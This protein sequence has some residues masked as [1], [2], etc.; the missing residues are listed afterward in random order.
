MWYSVWITNKLESL[1]LF[2]HAKRQTSLDLNS[3]LCLNGI[4]TPKINIIAMVSKLWVVDYLCNT[5]ITYFGQC[6]L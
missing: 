3:I 4:N 5:K 1:Y 6:G 2:I